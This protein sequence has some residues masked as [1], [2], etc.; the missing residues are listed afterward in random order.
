MAELLTETYK[1]MIVED[2]YDPLDIKEDT[3]IMRI[4]KGLSGGYKSMALIS[5][6]LKTQS[7]DEKM[8]NTESLEKQIE[9][10]E[11]FDAFG[12]WEKVDENSFMIMDISREET[13]KF[14]REYNQASY[15]WSDFYYGK[16]YMYNRDDSGEYILN[17]E[18]CE[19]NI[20]DVS[21]LD[22]D[23]VMDDFTI[24]NDTKF[25]IN[26]Y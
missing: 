26:F 19:R 9:E 6:E 13:E 18:C 12:R 4:V 23:T 24:V 5:A 15:I 16:H 20:E 7:N 22:M 14:A 2:E 10:Y 8:K 21:R 17:K 3:E 1:K 11:Y 25:R